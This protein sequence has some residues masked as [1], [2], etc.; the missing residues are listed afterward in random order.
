LVIERGKARAYT[1]NCFDWGERYPGIVS[2]AGKLPCRSA[3]LDAEIIVQ[4]ERGISDFD[5]LRSAIRWLPHTLRF[6]AFDL[7]HLNGEDLRDQQLLERRT[8]L[9]GLLGRNRTSPIQFSDEFIGDSAAFFRACA[10]HELEGVVP[11]VATSR[12]RS[13]CSKTW[14]K[15][16]CT[17]YNGGPLNGR[18]RT[19]H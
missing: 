18:C 2:A 1:R 13:G 10:K 4:D 16:K 12:Y 19:F 11:K 17:S 5:L 14:L 3:I 9:K 7:I 15:S 8:K 6:Y